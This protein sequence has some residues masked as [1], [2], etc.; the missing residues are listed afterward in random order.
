MKFQL[1]NYNEFRDGV[2]YSGMRWHDYFSIIINEFPIVL[3]RRYEFGVHRG[4]YKK[5]YLVQI[6]GFTI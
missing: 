3:V 2:D 5:C 6:L 1:Q 4:E